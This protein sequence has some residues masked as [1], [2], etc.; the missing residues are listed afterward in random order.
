MSEQGK[1]VPVAQLPKNSQL[2]SSDE[3]KSV[4]N[5]I[6][7]DQILLLNEN[8]YSFLPREVE[9]KILS[10]FENILA[11]K[12]DRD[13]YKIFLEYGASFSKEIKSR[14]QMSTPSAHRSINNLVEYGLIEALHK[15]K[16]SRKL[17]PRATLYA[18]YNVTDK[19]IELTVSRY[20]RSNT[21]YYANIEKL[22][23]RTLYE[24]QDESIQYSKILNIIRANGG[25][26]GYHFTDIADEI[27]KR[28]QTERGIKV[29]K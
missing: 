19:E 4:Y 29:W 11:S 12:N 1:L 18:V 2:F 17:G 8:N 7:E 6:K 3:N 15:I 16:Q 22:Y 9:K 27:G 26:F 28:L 25:S 20:M 5:I 21:K 24:I 23:Q 10:R 14:C 13:A